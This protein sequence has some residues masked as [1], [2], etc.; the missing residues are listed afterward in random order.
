MLGA[1]PE[2][3]RFGL[4]DEAAAR[5]RIVTT[6]QT[7]FDS[8]GYALVDTPVLE[9]YDPAH[10]RAAQSFKLSDRDSGVLALRSDFTPAIAHLVRSHFDEN[11]PQRF[12]YCGKAWQAINPDFARTREFTQVGLELTGISNPRADAELI[13]LAREAVREVGLVPR[14]ELGNPGFVRALFDLAEVPEDSQET[15]ANTIDRKDVAGL[16]EMLDSYK[17]S[18]DLK[19]ALLGVADLYGDVTILNEAR[20]LAPWPETLRALDDLEAILAE[21]EDLDELLL[22]FGRARR[23]SYYTGV[24]FQAYTFDFGQPLLGGGRYDGAL[25]PYAAGFT[26]GLERLLLALPPHGDYT[27]PLILS[28]DDAGARRLRAAGYRVERGLFANVDEAR[29][30]TLARGIPYLLSDAGL[31]A[32]TKNKPEYDDLL[33]LLEANYV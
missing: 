21:F 22:D 28:L 10:P 12:Q 1:P 24:T 5:V 19:A 27:P 2:G 7:L 13:H 9:H 31:E 18:P 29:A 26:I 25:L 14:V 20:Q 4:P 32:L 11:A 30:Y 16:E 33:N 15:L 23:L 3:T 6:L 8:W 17:L